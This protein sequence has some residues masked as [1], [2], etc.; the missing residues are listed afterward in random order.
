MN[1]VEQFDHAIYMAVL[2]VMEENDNVPTEHLLNAIEAVD[3]NSAILDA[4][5]VFARKVACRSRK[6]G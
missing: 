1:L 6:R 2:Q 3:V 4:K 5:D